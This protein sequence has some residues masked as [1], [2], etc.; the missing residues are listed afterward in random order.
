MPRIL[1]LDPATY[2][3]H[4]IHQ[5]DRIW[6]ETNCYTDIVVELLHAHGHA[7][8][9]ALAFTLGIDFEQDQW[10]FFKPP[11][12][13][14]ELLYGLSVQELALWRPLQ[15]HLVDQVA[16]GRPVL[17][18]LDSWFLPDTA[19]TAYRSAHVKT[20]VAVNEIDPDARVLGY[21]HNQGYYHLSGDDYAEILQ[22]GGLPHDRVLPPYAELV[23]P[24][25]RAVV[26]KGDDLT[27]ASLDLL[28]FHLRH[29]PVASP[30]R[31]FRDRFQADMDWLMAGELE[32]FHAYSFATL[33]QYGACYELAAT[34]LSWLSGRGV[35]GLAEPTADLLRIAE[36]TKSVQFLLARAMARKKPFDLATFDEL[37]EL[38]ER[39]MGTLVERHG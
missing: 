14:L 34:G 3:R 6:A 24:L 39:A 9:A 29:V 22:L 17:V 26:P 16:A 27:D 31:A 5:G 37:S 1:P 19:G 35:D 4:A 8:E 2:E 38:W 18:E 23:K 7:P 28:G 11:L 21:F 20:T 10:T 32:R 12:R 15:D 30:F 13:D 25:P 33:R 36:R